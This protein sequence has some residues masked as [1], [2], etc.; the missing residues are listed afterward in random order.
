MDRLHEHGLLLRFGVVEVEQ[1][2]PEGADHR[3]DD[4][5]DQQG[6]DED[7]AG[8]LRAVQEQHRNDHQE[9]ARV[10]QGEEQPAGQE[11]PDLLH[12][13][14]VSDEHARG[15]PLEVVDRETEQVAER[16]HRETDVDLVG[17]REQDVLPHE[18]EGGFEQQR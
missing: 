18:A 8:E 15:S 3:A 1:A 5:G 14:H 11:L 17:R 12:L 7:D 6:E 13:L 9:C 16:T 10:Q 4:G 2:A